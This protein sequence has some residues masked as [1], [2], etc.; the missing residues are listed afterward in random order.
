MLSER[1][2]AHSRK[3]FRMSD[4]SVKPPIWLPAIIFQAQLLFREVFN[5]ENPRTALEILLKLI[6]DERMGAVWKRLYTKNHSKDASD[7]YKYPGRG[8][9]VGIAASL[10]R[11]AQQLREQGDEHEAKSLEAEAAITEEGKVPPVFPRWSEQ[12]RAVQWFFWHIYKDALC[13]KPL[14]YPEFEGKS[15][16]LREVAHQLQMCAATLDSLQ[17]CLDAKRKLERIASDTEDE[18]WNSDPQNFKDDAFLIRRR[19]GNEQ[20]RTYIVGVSCSVYQFFGHGLHGTVATIANVVFGFSKSDSRAAD[21]KKVKD[22]I[23]M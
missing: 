15:S 23:G 20:W 6:C 11:K 10:R 2:C 7:E 18:A 1:R 13:T 3:V 4:P 16:K 8:T 5:E 14:I 9:Y 19:T 17:V 12:D 21:A 22:I